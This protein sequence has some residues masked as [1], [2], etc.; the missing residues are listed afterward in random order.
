MYFSK[1][2]KNSEPRQILRKK[3][4]NRISDS[5]FCTVSPLFTELT[6]QGRGLPGFTWSCDYG[7]GVAAGAWDRR[8][9][10]P[11]RCVLLPPCRRGVPLGK[12]THRLFLWR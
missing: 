9:T 12:L 2:I 8:K 3:Y 10:R 4:P 5:E 6:E 7:V 1:H 11:L